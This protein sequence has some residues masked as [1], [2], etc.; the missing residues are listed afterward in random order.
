MR[1]DKNHGAVVEVD[2]TAASRETLFLLGAR[3]AV[4]RWIERLRSLAGSQPHP[5]VAKVMAEISDQ[6]AVDRDGISVALTKCAIKDQSGKID[7]IRR[8]A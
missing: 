8:D 7:A 2:H 1:I 5:G 6:M 3:E 4:D